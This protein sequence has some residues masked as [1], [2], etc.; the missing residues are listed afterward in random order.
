M[1][2]PQSWTWENGETRSF[3]VGVASD[4]LHEARDLLERIVASHGVTMAGKG[5]SD[6][7]PHFC[8]TYLDKDQP[9]ASLTEPAYAGFTVSSAV[10]STPDAK[11][12]VELPLE[13]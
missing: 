12:Q 4:S 10:L 2:G 1:V 9:A 8:I 11:V 13:G 7:K 6:F 5:A 3:V